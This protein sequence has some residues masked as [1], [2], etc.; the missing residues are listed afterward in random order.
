[1]KNNFFKLKSF[2]TYWLDAVDEHSLHSPFFFD[3]YTNTI[4]DASDTSLFD[5]IEQLRIKLLS[6]DRSV[7]IVDFG[8]GSS[9]VKG[10]RRRISQIAK[11]S[12][13]PQKYSLL[14][15][16]ILDRFNCQN[17]LEL[18]TCLGINTLYLSLR[19]GC[20]V[21][22]FE[23]S[24]FL[25]EIAQESFMASGATNISVIPGNI[26]HTLAEF[27]RTAEQIDFAFLDANHRYE[28][29]LT[30]FNGI[31]QK[32]HHNSVVVL[33]DIHH[34]SEMERAWAD[35]LN[36]PSVYGT[37]DLYRC[38]LIF[39]DPSLNYQHHVLQF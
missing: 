3:L 30:Y 5:S 16:R 25:A 11:T 38:G 31:I 9:H 24:P 17:I 14:Y 13:S 10:S 26:D 23:G 19:E 28:P 2:F 20:R 15:Q 33:D 36:H 32:I 22:T 29:T 27:L 8:S 39:F 1:M 35:I 37:A 6:D 4:K 18:G 21:S 34:S 12:L 7:E